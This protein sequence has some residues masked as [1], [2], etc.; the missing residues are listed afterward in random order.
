MYQQTIREMAALVGRIGVNPRHV[1]AWMRLEHATLDWM[2][3]ER[4]RDEVEVAIACIDHAG[5]EQSEA[6][7]RSLGL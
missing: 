6:L 1:E 5:T 2:D 4:F 3:R 7:A